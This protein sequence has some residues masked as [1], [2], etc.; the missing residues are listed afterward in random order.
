MVSSRILHVLAA[1]ADGGSAL[2]VNGVESQPI[3]KEMHTILE[4]S[5]DAGKHK[6]PWCGIVKG[7][8]Y[9]KG[10]FE[11]KDDRGN[12]MTFSYCANTKNFEDGKKIFLSDIESL[13]YKV[14]IETSG[15][16]SSPSNKLKYLYFGIVGLI[17]ITLIIVLLN[18][19]K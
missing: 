10:F 15:T 16:L 8:F 5:Y 14:N 11:N 13:G 1:K 18:V 9:A 2:Y 4:L 17:A 6:S 3:C 19:L 7:Y 12:E